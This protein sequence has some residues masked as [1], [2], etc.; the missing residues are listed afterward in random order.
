[1]QKSPSS[2]LDSRIIKDIVRKAVDEDHMSFSAIASSA[3]LSVPTI[4]RL[5]EGTDMKVQA[6]TARMIASALGYSLEIKGSG[7]VRV[8]KEEDGNRR[9]DLTHGQK[10]RI[11][12]AIMRSVERELARF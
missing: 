5:Y 8:A 7:T 11:L 12:K 4:T 2:K 6:R 3:G 9:T 1:M 10:Q